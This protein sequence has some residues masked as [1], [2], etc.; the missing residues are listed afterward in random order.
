[1][2]YAVFGSSVVVPVRVH[3]PAFVTV[4]CPTDPAKIAVA[5]AL[6]EAGSTVNVG[7]TVYEPPFTTLIDAI[8]EGCSV[9][10]AFWV[11][12][13]PPPEIVTCGA[14]VYKPPPAT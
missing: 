4:T 14:L 1:M 13:L 2:K 12:V 3:D 5:V 9:A 8:G 11:D 10:M 6:A 7:A